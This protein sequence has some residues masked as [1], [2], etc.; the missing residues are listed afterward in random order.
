M[1]KVVKWLIGIFIVVILLWLMAFCIDYFRCVNLK[2]P[3]FAL[4][5]LNYAVKFSDGTTFLTC[6]CMG[7]RINL[8]KQGEK[9]VGTEMYLLENRIIKK[10]LP[11]Y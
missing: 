1:K 5:R 8:T 2:E 9:I 4:S 6:E 3:I 11:D 10:R 7:Y